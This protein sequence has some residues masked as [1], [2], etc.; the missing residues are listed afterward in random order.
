MSVVEKTCFAV[1]C[2]RC[3]DPYEEDEGPLHFATPES[4]A[5]YLRNVCWDTS[6]KSDGAAWYCEDCASRQLVETSRFSGHT[7]TLTPHRLPAG[8]VAIDGKV[9]RTTEVHS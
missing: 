6:G 2:D 9:R 5:A 8:M 1:A 7:A 3:G 4:A